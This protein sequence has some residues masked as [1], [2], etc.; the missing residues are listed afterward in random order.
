LAAFRKKAAENKHGA[1]W[2]NFYLSPWRDRSFGRESFDDAKK[3]YWGDTQYVYAFTKLIGDDVRDTGFRFEG[4]SDEVIRLDHT[5]WFMDD[6]CGSLNGTARGFVLMMPARDGKPRYFP[7]IYQS[8][9][10]EIMMWPLER[11]DDPKEVAR[12]AD[13]YAER[14]AEES[15]E[16]L[17]KDRREQKVIECQEDIDGLRK[18]IAADRIKRRQLSAVLR[19]IR[20]DYLP[21]SVVPKVLEEQ[22]QALLTDSKKAYQRIAKLKKEIEKNEN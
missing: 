6:D 12:W 13:Q 14:Y 7:A 20:P 19:K 2:K 21:G 9:S 5:G 16:Y 11:D 15:R 1:T 4:W 3:K 17:E 10:G 8:D 22:R 18:Q